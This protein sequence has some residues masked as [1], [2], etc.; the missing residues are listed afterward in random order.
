MKRSG[1]V[2]PS[3]LM[4]LDVGKCAEPIEEKL[5]R[6]ELL[7]LDDERMPRV[8]FEDRMIELR[9][10]LLARPVPELEDRRDQA[11]ARHVLVEAVFGEEIERGRMRG[12]GARV[13]LQLAIVVK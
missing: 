1:Q 4:H 5:C 7:A 9:D 13:G 3:N 2:K 12:G 8:V 11:D 6:L 10:Q